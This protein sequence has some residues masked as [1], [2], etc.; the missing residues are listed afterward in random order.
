M[1]AVVRPATPCTVT[2]L[3]VTLASWSILCVRAT[4]W[5][6][7][8][9][10][11]AGPENEGPDSVMAKSCERRELSA[12]SSSEWVT[13]SVGETEAARTSPGRGAG[14][15]FLASGAVFV[16]VAACDFDRAGVLVAIE[17]CLLYTS[18]A[19]DD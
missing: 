8:G 2:L 10:E 13:A 12:A 19:A 5:K 6:F 17:A 4:D 1:S 3:M 11:A 9:V 16:V 14:A 7:A 15:V 18:D